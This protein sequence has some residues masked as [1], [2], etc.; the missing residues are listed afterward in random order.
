MLKFELMAGNLLF[1]SFLVSQLIKGYMMSEPDVARVS[2]ESEAYVLIDENTP[3]EMDTD[4]AFI[5]ESIS[6][7]KVSWEIIVT[8]YFSHTNLSLFF[9]FLQNVCWE[10]GCY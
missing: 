5:E 7:S 10:C 8:E 2:G 3:E 4:E 1:G 9:F 6:I